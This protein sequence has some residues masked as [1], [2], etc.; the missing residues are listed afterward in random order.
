MTLERA[1]EIVTDVSYFGTMM[2]HL[3][4]A[5]GMVSGAAQH[6]GA[7]HPAGVRDHQ[8]RAGRL[9]GLERV[10]DVPGRPGAGLRRLRGHPRPDRR[11]AGRHRDL[12]G[13]DRRSSSA[14]SRGSRCCPTR[15]GQSGSGADV[16]KV[17]A[18]TALVRRAARRTCSSRG[19]S[20]TTPPSTRPSAATKMPD[21]DGRRARDGVHLPRP[22]HRQQHL[23]GGAAQRRRRRDR[24]GAAG[25][26]QAGQ[27]PVPRCARGGHRQHRRDHRHPGAGHVEAAG[28]ATA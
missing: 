24:P 8:D 2:V 25:P 14:S 20:S 19:R 27:R 23:Q 18:A 17:R 13:G 12:V 28:T 4:L 10:P 26:A 9:D 5:D 16:E 11:A 22:Q 15:P 3:G 21:S 7:H 1:R 6:H